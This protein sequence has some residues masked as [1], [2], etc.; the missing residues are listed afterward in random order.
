M[1]KRPQ[2]VGKKSKEPCRETKKRERATKKIMDYNFHDLNEMAKYEEFF[3]RF[4]VEEF[5]ASC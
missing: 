1:F 4:Y 2:R 5:H 3:E